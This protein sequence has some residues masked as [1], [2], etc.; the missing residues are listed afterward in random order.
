MTTAVLPDLSVIR[1]ALNDDPEFRLMA[2]LW[3]ARL[4]LE[5]G[6]D[7]YLVEVRDGEVA[8]FTDR[9]TLFDSFDIR[10]GGSTDGWTRLLA[11]EPEPMYQD[12]FRPCCTA[13]SRWGATSNRCSPI[14]PL[15]GGCGT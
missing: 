8:R 5:I 7:R 10:I 14:S 11:L 12:L 15:C 6:D 4:V 1:A 13:A 2:R 9:V 3:T